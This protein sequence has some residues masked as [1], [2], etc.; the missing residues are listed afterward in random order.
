VST[1]SKKRTSTYITS[2]EERMIDES[3]GFTNI[4]NSP[5][6]LAAEKSV[7]DAQNIMT[8]GLELVNNITLTLSTIA[9]GGEGG[10]LGTRKTNLLLIFHFFLI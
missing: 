7:L 8:S 1:D 2:L 6:M 3:S 10:V 4:E 9:A 5:A